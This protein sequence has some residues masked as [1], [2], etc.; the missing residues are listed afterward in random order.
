MFAELVETGDDVEA[1]RA[2]DLCLVF[3]D[4]I[5]Q[6]RNIDASLAKLFRESD[7]AGSKP[8]RRFN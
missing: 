2:L 3:A 8:S 1:I 4:W 5:I 6:D 7:C